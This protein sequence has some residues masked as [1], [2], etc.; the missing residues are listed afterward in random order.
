MTQP[1]WSSQPAWQPLWLCATG[2]DGQPDPNV[3]MTCLSLHRHP[4]GD[5]WSS[6]LEPGEQADDGTVGPPPLHPNCRCRI[7]ISPYPP[8]H[9]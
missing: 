3:C 2:P 5:A 6:Q 7:D 9:S 1:A 4:E 8:A